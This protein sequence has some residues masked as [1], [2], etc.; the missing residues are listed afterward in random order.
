MATS[1]PVQAQLN[2]IQYLEVVQASL[3]TAKQGNDCPEAV[4]AATTKGLDNMLNDPKQ[5]SAVESKFR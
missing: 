1:A 3:A 5:L 4:K 2:F